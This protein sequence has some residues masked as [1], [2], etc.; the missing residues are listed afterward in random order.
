MCVSS[1]LV[2]YKENFASENRWEEAEEGERG[3]GKMKKGDL[4]SA[5]SPQAGRQ[6]TPAPRAQGGRTSSHQLRCDVQ[7]ERTS[8]L[9]QHD[10]RV[11]QVLGETHGCH[12]TLGAHVLWQHEGRNIHRQ[13]DGSAQQEEN[14][15]SSW[16]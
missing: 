15:L 7:V 13:D 14:S 3:L 8:L 6:G 11:K 16:G 9:Q 2:K 12:G 10:D 4:T 5:G 1:K